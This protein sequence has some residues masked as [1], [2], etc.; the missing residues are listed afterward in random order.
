MWTVKTSRERRVWTLKLAAGVAVALGLATVSCSPAYVTSNDAAVNLIIA[1]ISP[2]PV[3][4]DIRSGSQSDTGTFI[5]PDFVSVAVAV[6]NKNPNAPAPNVANAVLIQ[7]YEVRY[8]RTDGRGVEGVDVPYRI[9]GNLSFAEDVKTSGT[10][11]LPIEVVRYQAKSEPP[12]STIFQTAVLTVEA[13]ITLYGQTVAGQRVSAT[14]AVQINFAEFADKDT[15]CP[16][17]SSSP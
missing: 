17:T 16:T 3:T 15:Q 11:S 7:S 14:G 2:S 1:A 6:R 5:C 13:Q 12:L 8:T 9:T 10:D 4:S